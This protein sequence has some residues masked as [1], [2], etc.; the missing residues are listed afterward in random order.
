MLRMRWGIARHI[1]ISVCTLSYYWQDAK[2]IPFVPYLAIS[3]DVKTKHYC[4]SLKLETNTYLDD[5][6]ILEGNT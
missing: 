6:A 1:W 5:L 4:H 3:S 2:T